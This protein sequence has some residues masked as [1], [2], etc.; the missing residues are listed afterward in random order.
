M[1]RSM[2]FL[3]LALLAPFTPAIDLYCAHAFYSPESGFYNNT[4]FIILFK[5]GELFGLATGGMACAALVLS[6]CHRD[7]KKWRRGAMAMVLTLVIGAGLITNLGLKGYWGRP[8]PKQIKEFGGHH[9]YR[10][11]WRP[12]FHTRCDPQ[13]S[14]PSGHVAMGF[15]F[16]SLWLVGKRYRIPLLKHMGLFFVAFLGG[17]LM[18]TR[19]AQGGHFFSDVV[20]SPILMWYVAK[21]IDW[22][23]FNSP[24]AKKSQ[25]REKMNDKIQRLRRNPTPCELREE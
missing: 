12:N 9:S 24:Y 20:F 21:G 15:Y 4:L 22:W 8:R 23:V 2:W 25:R 6:F 10:P 1:I 16:L 18:L 7:W 3:L 11:F 19:V 14:F 5:Y 13:R 17:G